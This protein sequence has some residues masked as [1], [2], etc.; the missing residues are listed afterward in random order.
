MR[1]LLLL[2][3][4][5]ILLLLPFLSVLACFNPTDRYSVEVMLNKPD[6]TFDLSLLEKS[7][8]VL[9]LKISPSGFGEALAYVSHGNKDVAVVLYE[10]KI[11]NGSERIGPY[12]VV[13]LQPRTVGK[14]EPRPVVE[15][16]NRTAR[17]LLFLEIRWLM[18]AGIVKGLAE[19]DVKQIC[20]KAGLG[21]AG[22]NSRIVFHEGR[23]VS[24]QET[25]YPKVKA[26]CSF[27]P[28]AGRFPN[29]TPP[30]GPEFGPT[31]WTVVFFVIS[32]CALLAAGLI[33][34]RSHRA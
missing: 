28:L 26:L 1:S 29:R 11:F 16:D 18:G 14:Y 8:E 4:S 33:R 21:M 9:K 13:R 30:G 15:L 10:D 31:S 24:F 17:R 12:L 23:W 22:Y 7:S 5:L 3:C 32:A 34:S 27:D 6:V 19:E 20:S 2:L 25:P